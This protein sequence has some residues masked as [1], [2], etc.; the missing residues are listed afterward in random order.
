MKLFSEENSPAILAGLSVFGVI[1]TAILAYKNTVRALDLIADENHERYVDGE[2]S[3]TPKEETKLTWKCYIPT[4]ISM[5][6]TI[7]C[8][9][10]SYY[11]SVKQTEAISSAYLLS[12]A[13]LHEYQRKVIDRI[14]ENK[15]REIRDEAIREIADRRAPAVLYSSEELDII[16]TGHGKTLFYDIPGETYFRSDINFVKSV[17]NDLNHDV[18]TEM[19][20][21][22]NEIRYRWGLPRKKF[23]SELIFDVD[24]P[25]EIY[26]EP[27]LM[28]NGQVRILLNYELYPRHA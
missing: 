23:G 19:L 20:Y 11:C 15:E 17:V 9:V 10:G 18:R 14:G 1:S 28:E 16:E 13:T 7:G 22:W 8:I 6:G 5:I 3:L 12:Q 24:R 2:N 21:D 27:E 4:T 25:L 26:L